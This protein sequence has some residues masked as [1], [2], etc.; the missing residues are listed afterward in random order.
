MA[1]LAHQGSDQIEMTTF[2]AVARIGIPTHIGVHLE[3]HI[4]AFL[5]GRHQ[6]QGFLLCASQAQV[7]ARPLTIVAFA[8]G[9]PSA[10]GEHP[11]TLTVSPRDDGDVGR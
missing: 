2:D 8:T 10:Q 11:P 4:P 5:I 3:G 6:D 9:D 7:R 1:D